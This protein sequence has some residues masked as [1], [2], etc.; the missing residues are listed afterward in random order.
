MKLNPDNE[1]MDTG[2]SISARRLFNQSKS[3]FNDYPSDEDQ[4]DDDSLMGDDVSGLMELRKGYNSKNGAM[5]TPRVFEND[6]DRSDEDDD[7]YVNKSKAEENAGWSTRTQKM[8]QYL[9]DKEE[10]DFVYQEMVKGKA[11]I[12]A[13]GFFYELLVLK[14]HVMIDLKQE[15]AYGKIDFSKTNNITKTDEG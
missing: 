12:T 1:S 2:C 9:T 8:L 15:E 14:T 3:I 5:T 7:G 4:G 11:R 13:V 10:S 6:G